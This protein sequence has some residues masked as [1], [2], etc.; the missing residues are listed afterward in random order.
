MRKRTLGW[1]RRA[2]AAPARTEAGPESAP[3]ASIDRIKSRTNLSAAPEQ[4]TRQ[5]ELRRAADQSPGRGD[6]NLRQRQP[7]GCHNVRMPHRHG[8]DVSTPRNWDIRHERPAEAHDASGA[9]CAWTARFFVLEPPWRKPFP[10]RITRFCRRG[11][12]PKRNRGPNGK[13][14]AEV[15]RNQV[16]TQE[17]CSVWKNGAFSLV[18]CPIGA[19]PQA[20]RECA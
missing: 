17:R 4:L 3:M 12:I 1:R 18:F 20:F 14:G 11:D 10:Y 19:R 9:Y 6:F 5:M 13:Q 8:V 15:S 7:R 2:M 16:P